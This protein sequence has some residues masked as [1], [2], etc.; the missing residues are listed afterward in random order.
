MKYKNAEFRDMRLIENKLKSDAM[1]F[2]Q[3][4]S[5]ALH[6][7][8]MQNINKQHKVVT[9]DEKVFSIYQWLVPTG[10]AMGTLLFV[11]LNIQ[12]ATVV[13]R[14]NMTLPSNGQ[15]MTAMADMMAS[16][17]VDLLPQTL[18]MK[19][20]NHIKIEQ[21]ALQQDLKYLKSLFVL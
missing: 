21:Q 16:F 8:I 9:R 5:A 14:I 7:N 13:E 10:F 6:E 20:T 1:A 3:E 17:K 15:E 11:G 12:Q 2:R 19:L 18:E 4:P